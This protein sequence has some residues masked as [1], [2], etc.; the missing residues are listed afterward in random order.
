MSPAAPI[1]V[2]HVQGQRRY[3]ALLLRRGGKVQLIRFLHGETVLA[4]QA[5]DWQLDH[6]Y[7]LTL[8]VQEGKIRGRVDGELE[9]SASD[10]SLSCGAVALLCEEGNTR[11]GPVT[12]KPWD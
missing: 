11:F 5:F 12:V 9:L 10:S 4:E 6:A 3:Y 7:A 2:V 8:S 1:L